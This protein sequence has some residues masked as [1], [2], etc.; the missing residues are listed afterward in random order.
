MMIYSIH[1][2]LRAMKKVVFVNTAL[3]ARYAFA[4]GNRPSV[5]AG[6]D[7]TVLPYAESCTG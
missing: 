6:I 1:I 2:P 5:L 4:A 3:L 7:G